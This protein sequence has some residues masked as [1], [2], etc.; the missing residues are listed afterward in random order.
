MLDFVKKYLHIILAIV[1]VVMF[2]ISAG[3]MSD[4]AYEMETLRSV[5]GTSVAEAYY[6]EHGGVIDGEAIAVRG[7][8]IALA[9]IVLYVGEL[10]KKNN[11]NEDSKKENQ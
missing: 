1:I 5:G 6:Q 4:H 7:L 9:S 2:F 10:N 11:I 8:G 3:E